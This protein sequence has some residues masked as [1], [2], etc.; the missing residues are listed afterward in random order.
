MARDSLTPEGDTVTT[1]FT[2]KLHTL[3]MCYRSPDSLWSTKDRLEAVV[4]VIAPDTKMVA[5][6]NF[7]SNMELLFPSQQQYTRKTL[8]PLEVRRLAKGVEG[9]FSSMK[10][11]TPAATQTGS[12]SGSTTSTLNNTK[13]ENKLDELEAG[14]DEIVGI[15]GEEAVPI[16][17]FGKMLPLACV[18]AFFATPFFIMAII[19]ILAAIGYLIVR[20]RYDGSSMMASLTLAFPIMAI[21]AAIGVVVLAAI[22]ARPGCKDSDENLDLVRV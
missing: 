3:H 5:V 8:D 19:A 7:V 9:P 18:L 21:L 22:G 14:M 17:K 12:Q 20:I 11:K 13:F 2:K 15:V 4:L 6:V 10:V 1:K 16:S